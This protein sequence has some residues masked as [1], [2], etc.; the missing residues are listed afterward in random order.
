MVIVIEFVG[1]RTSDELLALKSIL[2]WS[3]PVEP[4]RTFQD[5]PEGLVE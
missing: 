4:I 5:L 1:V 2:V 3:A